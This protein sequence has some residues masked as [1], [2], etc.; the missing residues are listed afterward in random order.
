MD[1]NI[2][3]LVNSGAQPSLLLDCLMDMQV[4]SPVLPFPFLSLPLSLSSL[5]PPMFL[6]PSPELL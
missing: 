2:P 3:R 6:H 1:L 4:P 5:T